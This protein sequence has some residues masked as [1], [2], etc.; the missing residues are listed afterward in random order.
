MTKKRIIMCICHIKED[1]CRPER[2]ACFNV[3]VEN[4][5]SYENHT[6]LS[7]IPMRVN[8]EMKNIECNVGFSK[9][10]QTKYQSKI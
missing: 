3:N 6:L 4:R 8:R 7:Y 1:I 5:K 9:S 2:A 10:E